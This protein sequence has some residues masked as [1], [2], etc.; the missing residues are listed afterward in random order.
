MTL[1]NIKLLVGKVFH[2][3]LIERISTG[4][5]NV[6]F[7]GRCLRDG[8]RYYLKFDRDDY[9]INMSKQLSDSDFTLKPHRIASENL[10]SS[11][12][13]VKNNVTKK[14]S[15]YTLLMTEEM[16]NGDLLNLI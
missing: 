7:I 1:R 16:I 9:E 2:G 11:I 6:G 12:S 4:S 8:K 5:A 10:P 14:L 13:Y 3:F 15:S